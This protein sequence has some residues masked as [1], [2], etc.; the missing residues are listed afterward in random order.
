MQ[1]AGYNVWANKRLTEAILALSPELRSKEIKS[2]FPSLDKTL[3]HMLDAETIWWQRMKLLERIVRPSDH[4]NGETQDIVSSLLQTNAQWQEWVA[5]ASDA[6]LQHVF[7]YQNSRKESFKQPIY[8]MLMHVFNHGTY[9]RG[10]LVTMMR[11]V[12]VEKIPE[13]DLILFA[14]GKK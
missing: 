6:A 9:H 13:T 11:A 12:G 14:R 5:N 3:L 8:H 4:F 7:Q 2:S 1:Y 10:Q